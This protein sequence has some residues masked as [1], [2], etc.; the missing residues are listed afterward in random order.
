MHFDEEAKLRQ[1]KAPC[2]SSKSLLSLFNVVY[3]ISTKS[4]TDSLSH[5]KWQNKDL[6]SSIK[7]LSEFLDESW[8]EILSM[9]SERLR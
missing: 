1:C 7:S 8:L 4:N 3:N 6:M 9:V 2:F 5:D